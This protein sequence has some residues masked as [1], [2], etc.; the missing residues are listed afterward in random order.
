MP[1]KAKKKEPEPADNGVTRPMLVANY[2][3]MCRSIGV[4]I[5]AHMADAL[6]GKGD[7]AEERLTQL[8]IDDEFGV[9]GNG[10]M[11]AMAC[12]YG[13][14]PHSTTAAYMHLSTIRVWNNAIGNEGASAIASMLCEGNGLVNIIY[15]ELMD[16]GI[17]VEGCKMLADALYANKKSPLQTLK[18]NCNNDIGDEGVAELCQGLFTNT[19][20][21]VLTINYL[22]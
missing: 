9:L 19:T 12:A 13:S 3:K 20:L 7:E 16:C 6:K 22:T 18:L 14:V 11:R 17:S 4:P 5:N 21:K 8:L 1:P 10:G 2:T 15:V